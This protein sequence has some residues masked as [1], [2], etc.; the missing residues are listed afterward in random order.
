MAKRML[1]DFV[2]ALL[3]KLEIRRVYRPTTNKG[4][5]WGDYRLFSADLIVDTLHKWAIDKF[6]LVER[7]FPAVLCMGYKY[8]YMSQL[9]KGESSQF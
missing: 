4:Y 8:R 5:T 2:T 6:L 1:V 9:Q 3:F 7:Q